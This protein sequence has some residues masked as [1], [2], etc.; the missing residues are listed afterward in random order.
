MSLFNIKPELHKNGFACVL[1]PDS[2]EVPSSGNGSSKVHE[3]DSVSIYQTKYWSIK[4]DYEIE[5]GVVLFRGSP[6]PYN[7]NITKDDITS[8]E[9]M[10]GDKKG[11]RDRSSVE[12]RGFY[13][14]TG[15][16]STYMSTKT[17]RE[18]DTSKHDR[19]Q[20]TNNPFH[21]LKGI[22][23]AEMLCE[24]SDSVIKNSG[25]IMMDLAMLHADEVLKRNN[26][27]SKDAKNSL[28]YADI[29]MNRIVT[30]WFSASLHIDKNDTVS[31]EFDEVINAGMLKLDENIRDFKSRKKIHEYKNKRFGQV[32]DYLLRYKNYKENNTCKWTQ[33]CWTHV[34]ISGKACESAKK[35]LYHYFAI[36]TLGV[37]LDI[38]PDNMKVAYGASFHSNSLLH[39]TSI[40]VVVDDD[41]DN[42]I[43]DLK[44]L[45][46]MKIPFAWGRSGSVGRA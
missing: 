33:C 13:S 2:V 15:P 7:N 18:C 45:T 14:Y 28:S 42:V 19:Y 24:Q 34:D 27:K 25:N 22:K 12:M 20:K 1:L 29:C 30:K 39:G 11:L 26:K 35:K 38:G 40:P 46:D 3:N 43:V 6:W 37:C 9:K 10:H 31:S 5:G 16:R 23:L 44:Q 17:I 36:E 21:Y 4:Q 32:D 41:D 8:F